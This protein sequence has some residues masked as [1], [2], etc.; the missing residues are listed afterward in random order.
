MGGTTLN[1]ECHSGGEY[2]EYPKAVTLDGKRLE[3]KKI[4]HQWRSQSGKCFRL[5]L[6]NEAEVQIEYDE[7]SDCWKLIIN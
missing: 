4:L 1:V 7:G 6:E 3:V 2:A 5:L